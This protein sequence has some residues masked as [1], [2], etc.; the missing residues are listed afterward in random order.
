M[1]NAATTATPR[2]AGIPQGI[3]IV[4]TA[5]LPIMAIVSLAPALPSIIG[6]FKAEPQVMTLGPLMIT[7]PGIMIAL[8]SPLAGWA[9]D[10]F[11][12]RPVLIVATGI[13]GLFGI[14]PFFLN[15]LAPIFATRLALG[16]AEAGILTACNTLIG[17]YFDDAR[18]RH[19]LTVQGV[20]GPVFGTSVVLL[21]GALTERWWN[22]A[23]LIYGVAILIFFAMLAF[24]FEPARRE[25]HAEGSVAAS[26]FPWGPVAALAGVTLFVSTL[27]YGF[28][29]QG[30]L[31]F[32]AVGVTS[33]SQTGLLIS[34]ASAGVFIGAVI[35][36][37][38]S[39]R[40][41]I[42]ALTTILLACFGVGMI[43][44][45]LSPNYRIATATAFIQQLG[46]G[47]AV[48]TLIYWAARILPPEHRGRGMGIWV[49]AFFLGQFSSPLFFSFA[50][51]TSGGV[52]GGFM[53]FGVV[54]L[55]GALAAMAINRR[56]LLR[57][58]VAVGA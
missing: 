2:R 14:A 16:L 7:A 23:F 34:I 5:F 55:V 53:V 4:V 9:A 51:E 36:G 12:R 44:I 10:R 27:Y 8:L 56:D 3:V 15:D 38:L 1:T 22:G 6:H 40:L 49:S 41:S 42:G 35:F 32:Q 33:P 39:K 21:A 30:G 13:Y 54:A 37:F 25:R 57:R 26:G 43:G 28:I 19:W 47:M 18:R 46:A 52:L 11:G 24:I 20:V 58:E 31:A 48:P 45:G 29:V 17:D 50:R